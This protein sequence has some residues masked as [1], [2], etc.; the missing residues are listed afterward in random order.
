MSKFWFTPRTILLLTIIPGLAKT[1]VDDKS[2]PTTRV[3][4]ATFSE[5]EKR[6]GKADLRI[7]DARSKADYDKGHIPGAVWVDVRAAEK[8]ASKPG[9]LV[10]KAAWEAWIA[11]LGLAPKTET[12]VYDGR[13]QLEAARVWW[14]LSYLG[15]ERVGLVDGNYPLWTTEKHPVTTEVP[16]I[17][18]KPFRV[19]F[20]TDKHATR[21]DVLA[22]VA[23][24]SAV[25]VD[26][27]TEGEYNGKSKLAKRGG[28]IPDACRLEWSNL[29]GTDGRF[30]A[31]PALKAKLAEAGIEERAGSTAITHC[32]GG[33]RSSVDAFVLER[34]GFKTRN[35]YLGWSDWGN[36]ENTPVEIDRRSKSKQ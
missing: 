3:T 13:R 8:L 30:L 33:G 18:P 14:L 12:L 22:A 9:G 6:I 28:H 35:Y 17:D 25:V 11:P 20:Q 27:R 5:L 34:L 7:L 23:A 24:K 19:E 31:E 29:V 1:A 4:L 32:Q 16:T 2:S 26:A 10:D 15:V 21:D 36:A